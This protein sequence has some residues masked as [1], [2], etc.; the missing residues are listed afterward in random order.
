MTRSARTAQGS[1]AVQ[2]TPQPLYQGR[3]RKPADQRLRGHGLASG[4]LI[5]SPTL[6]IGALISARRRFCHASSAAF[7]LVELVLV[8]VI[9]GIVA[10][11]AVPRMTRGGQQAQ[12]KALT[13]TL[14]SVRR[15]IDYYYAEHN[16]FPGYNPDTLA[17]DGQ[18]FVDQ[19]TKW[20][21]ARGDVSDVPKSGSNLGPYLRTPFPTNPINGLDTVKVRATRSESVSRGT[22][23]WIATLSDGSFHAN[24]SEQDLIDIGITETV[25]IEDLSGIKAND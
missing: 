5:G 9:I 1:V 6:R 12:A 25:Q 18:W 22:T 15:A 16:R 11:I 8:V 24:N 4:A 21:N 2:A 13:A 17:P 7:S 3:W 23:G 14:E 10:A 20:S 19:L